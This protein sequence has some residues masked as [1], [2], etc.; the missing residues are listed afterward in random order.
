ME[1]VNI[2]DRPEFRKLPFRAR[3]IDVIIINLS[4]SDIIN[5]DNDS[6]PVN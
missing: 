4:I 3:R 2:K 5:I 6:A 1:F